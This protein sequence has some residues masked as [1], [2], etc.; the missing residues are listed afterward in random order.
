MENHP[1]LVDHPIKRVPNWKECTV[2]LSFHGDGV[3]VTSKGKGWQK[4]ADVY[5]FCSM[6]FLATIQL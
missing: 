2:A 1:G 5:S 4:S 6:L 3:P